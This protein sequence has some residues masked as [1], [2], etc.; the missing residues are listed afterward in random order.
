[1]E[2][3]DLEVGALGGQLADQVQDQ[4]LGRD[5]ALELALADHLDGPRHLDVQHLAQGPDRGHLGGADAEG[6]GAQGAVAGGVAVGA[7]HDAARPHV[8][9][10]GQDL[11]ADAAAVAADVVELGDPLLGHEVADLL[12]VAG[13]LRA[14][15][16]HAVVE[17]DG[18]PGRVPDLGL[19]PRVL[20]DLVE[21]VDDQGAVLV[22]HGQVDPG[23]EHVVR[24]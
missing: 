14:F 2:L 17:D 6:E 8:A 4:V 5:V 11:V 13:R 23:L 1:M 12:L 19:E 22:R 16:R 21:L 9:E 24:P 20:V 7:D 18:D 15:G 10:L 3:D